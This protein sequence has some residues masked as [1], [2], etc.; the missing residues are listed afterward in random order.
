MNGYLRW[1]FW[2]Y[3]IW[4]IWMYS[5]WIYNLS[6]CGTTRDH[7]FSSFSTFLTIPSCRAII[8]ELIYKLYHLTTTL[9][10]IPTNLSISLG[11]FSSATR[12]PNF[13]SWYS[14]EWLS[15]C[16]T[17][18]DGETHDTCQSDCNVDKLSH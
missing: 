7:N 12:S 4:K 3:E 6:L 2:N 17:I 11:T 5:L 15:S 18:E 9:W 13:V 1:L 16:F 14:S 8:L 10:N